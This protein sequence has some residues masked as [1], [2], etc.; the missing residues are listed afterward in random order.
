MFAIKIENQEFENNLI[1]FAKTQKKSIEDVAIDAMKYFM[2]LK[3]KDT[4]VYTKKD[5]LKH[6]RTINYD[7]DGEDLSDVKPFAHID[8]AA[9]YVHDL[10]RV[11]AK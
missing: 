6:L 4:L 1:E 5:P 3:N 8:D 11:R 9:K 2:N 7:Y 10:R